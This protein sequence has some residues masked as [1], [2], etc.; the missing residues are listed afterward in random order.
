MRSHFSNER[1][2]WLFGPFFSD[3]LPTLPLGF[4]QEAVLFVMED[5]EVD[6]ETT[7]ELF[8][9][10][11]SEVS[12]EPS[13]KG[14]TSKMPFESVCAR[15]MVVNAPWCVLMGVKRVDTGAAG[16]FEVTVVTSGAVVASFCHEALGV[17]ETLANRSAGFKVAEM[18][19]RGGT[20]TAEDAVDGVGTVLGSR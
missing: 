15:K 3:A 18:L 1:P 7:T 16:G 2:C 13:G 20:V 10:F 19:R 6:K 17:T 12:V 5:S 11:V 14:T 9:C 4:S 8:S